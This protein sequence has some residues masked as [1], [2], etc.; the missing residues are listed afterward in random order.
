[1]GGVIRREPGEFQ[2]DAYDL[3]IVGGG[4][5][6][7][8]AILAAARAGHRALLLEREDFG[9]A[10]SW[11]SLRV[12][13]GGL[14]YLQTLDLRR[15]RQS[16]RARSW[17]VEEL[18]ELVEPLPCLMPLYGEGL[19]RRSTLGPALVVNEWLRRRWSSPAELEMLPEGRL[20]SKDEVIEAFGAVRRSGLQGGALWYDGLLPCPQRALI[21]MLRRAVSLGARALNHME[22]TDVVVREGR[23]VAVQARD[24]L[25]WHEYEFRTSHVLNCAGPWAAAIAAQEDPGLAAAFHP[26]LAFNLLLD[27]PL[28]SAVSVAVEPAGGGRTYFLQPLDDHTLAG[29]YHA[30]T[31]AGDARPTPEQI[32]DFL[33]DLRSA[34]PD[35]HVTDE[36][37]LRVMS[38]VLPARRPGT[39][40]LSTRP[41]LRT[42][43]D[44]DG[45][46]GLHSLVG[47]KYTTAPLA[48]HDA[49]ARIFG[50]EIAIGSRDDDPPNVREV[51]DWTTFGLWA[52]RD[53][54]AAGAL[55]DAIVGEESVM[56]PDDLLLRRTDWGLDPSDRN[57][58]EA[59]IRQIRPRLF[60]AQP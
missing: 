24:S 14:R 42:P 43:A 15:F 51:P 1:M 29:T 3:V 28:N 39:A 20:L 41:L 31:D 52:D 47:V 38:G 2:D 18:P 8:A 53:P 55:L 59:R 49:I 56:E 48:A 25:A 10:T 11:N 4:I 44:H 34:I 7:V 22:L 13:H 19:R 6:G 9:G 33:A 54:E 32:D 17:F 16:V 40:E 5:Y 23:V 12:L 46:D 30:P 50:P 58:T 36:H 26:S 35:F 27:H 21:E 57:R 37:V 45:P 60:D